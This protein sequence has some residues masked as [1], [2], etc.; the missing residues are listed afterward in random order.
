MYDEQ[1]ELFELEYS[2]DF[3]WADQS[4]NERV[5][6]AV[7]IDKN[8][9]EITEYRYKNINSLTTDLSNGG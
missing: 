5:Q 7:T 3:G 2:A 1:D 6:E 8:F 9:I 4:G